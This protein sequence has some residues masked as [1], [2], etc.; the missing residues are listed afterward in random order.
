MKQDTSIL[1]LGLRFQEKHGVQSVPNHNQ[2]YQ[3]EGQ[4]DFYFPYAFPELA[5]QISC[6]QEARSAWIPDRSPQGDREAQ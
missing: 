3:P 4:K 2:G 5:F 6:I 1:P